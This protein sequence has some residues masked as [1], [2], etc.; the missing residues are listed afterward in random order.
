MITV[1]RSPSGKHWNVLANGVVVEA[2]YNAKWKAEDMADSY[3]R[4]VA[5]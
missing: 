4:L 2:G 1:E 5:K 3:R